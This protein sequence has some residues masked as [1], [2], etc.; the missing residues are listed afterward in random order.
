MDGTP[1][2]PVGPSEVALGVLP[3]EEV[4]GSRW[5]HGPGNPSRVAQGPAPRRRC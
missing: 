4:S 5:P 3:Q 1:P 2:C